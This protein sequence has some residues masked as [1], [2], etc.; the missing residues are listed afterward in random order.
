MSNQVSPKSMPLADGI[1]R[2]IQKVGHTV[3]WVY[4]LLI[5]AIILQ[6]VL[7][8]G[9]SNGLIVLE[10]LQ[11][12]LYAAGVMFGL[13]YAQ[14]TNSHIRV[15]I[16]YGRFS[17]KTKSIV[18]ILGILL[19]MLPFVGVV[20]YHSLDFVYDAW[21]IGETSDSPSGLPYRWL[22][23]A[24]IPLSMSLLA[25]S[26]FAKLIREINFLYQ[27]DNHGN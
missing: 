2:F 24:I 13:S 19:L 16:L 4:V 22:V 5:I 14:T 9:F 18:D 12:H 21:R 6:V 1:D 11:W 26:M 25:L 8:K 23:K 7:R 15:D 10:E 17:A 3:V 27:G 20:F